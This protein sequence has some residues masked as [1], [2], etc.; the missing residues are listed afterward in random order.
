[1][2]AFET[3]RLN[4]FFQ[5]LLGIWVF[6]F[7]IKF[8]QY[9]NLKT[10]LSFAVIFV[11]SFFISIYTSYQGIGFLTVLM[12]LIYFYSYKE[13]FFNF[14]Y[15]KLVL[16]FILF[17]LFLL[18]NSFKYFPSAIVNLLFI[19]F[20]PQIEKINKE[21]FKKINQKYKYVFYFFYPV[22]LFLLKILQI[23]F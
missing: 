23:F 7:L 6:E 18:L 19:V 1:M 8:I 13:N 4:I 16:W 5:F 12:L 3:I 17:V 10:F 15:F 2:F 11:F 20:L 21:Q 9:K 22:H 14:R